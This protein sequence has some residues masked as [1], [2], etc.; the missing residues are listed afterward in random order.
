MRGSM[1]VKFFYIIDKVENTSIAS[2]RGLPTVTQW[3]HLIKKISL[4][5]YIYIYIFTYIPSKLNY[6]ELRLKV[7]KYHNCRNFFQLFSCIL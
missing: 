4:G 2:H 7:V 5:V 1:P 6:T 3:T